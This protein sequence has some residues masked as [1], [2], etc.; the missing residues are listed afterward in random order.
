M[1]VFK[2]PYN[3]VILERLFHGT[4]PQILNIAIA[5]EAFVYILYTIYT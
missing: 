1:R 2:K 3:I 4:K 5:E